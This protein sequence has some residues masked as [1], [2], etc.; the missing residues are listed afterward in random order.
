MVLRLG[1]PHEDKRLSLWERIRVWINRNLI[2]GGYGLGAGYDCGECGS[3]Q[4][5]YFKRFR[6]VSSAEWRARYE[7]V[8]LPPIGQA[9]KLPTHVFYLSGICKYCGHVQQVSSRP[10]RVTYW[11]N[12]NWY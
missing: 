10:N 9:V 7:N 4:V 12:D 11:Y 6:P 1:S 2:G 3:S 5:T 8:F